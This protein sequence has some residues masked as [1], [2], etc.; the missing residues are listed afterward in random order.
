MVTHA[1]TMETLTI[2]LPVNG[3]IA[4]TYN[5][6]GQVVFSRYGQDL[7]SFSSTAGHLQTASWSTL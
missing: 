4:K 6:L 3:N 1:V 5:G 7:Q 2:L